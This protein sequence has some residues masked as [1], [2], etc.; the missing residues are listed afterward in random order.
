MCPDFSLC[1]IRIRAL[2]ESTADIAAVLRHNV[3]YA[4]GRRYKL[5]VLPVETW[6]KEL[7][8]APR[9]AVICPQ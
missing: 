2:V 8:E 6:R 9:L 5:H 4:P 3:S 1:C 7:Y